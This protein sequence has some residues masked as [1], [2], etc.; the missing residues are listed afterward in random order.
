MFLFFVKAKEKERDQRKHL[1]LKRHQTSLRTTRV[2][3]TTKR[4]GYKKID[5]QDTSGQPS[6]EMS[7]D[8][9][10]ALL[11]ISTGAELLSAVREHFLG[12]GS[13]RNVAIIKGKVMKMFS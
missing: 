1:A 8:L 5:K 2:P 7:A 3:F 9:P 11:P 4:N 10:F 13:V 12:F 6:A